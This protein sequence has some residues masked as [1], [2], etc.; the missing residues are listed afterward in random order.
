MHGCIV[1]LYMKKYIYKCKYIYI[2]LYYFFFFL[3]H[4]NEQQRRLWKKKKTKK[5]GENAKY[6]N[7]K[8]N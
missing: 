7:D 5:K 6:E 1:A 4:L 2:G 3:I 8:I